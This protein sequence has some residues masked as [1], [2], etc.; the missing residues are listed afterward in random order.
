[1]SL[2]DVMINELRDL[3][4]AELQLT[5]ALPKMAKAASNPEL[6]T[7]FTEHLE[8]TK[9]QVERLKQ[10]FEQIGKKPT[11][12]TCHGMQGLVEEAQQH[13]DEDLLPELKDIALSGAALRVEHY[14]VAGYT[15]SILIAK[16]LG[17][18]QIADLLK[19][20]LEEEKATAKRLLTGAK[21]MLKT[22]ASLA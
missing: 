14:E 19:Q 18:T 5:K 21:P 11:G 1:M 17:E 4:S 15:A 16:Q 12:E 10:I 8:Q 22:A 20:T 3:Y 6:K 13:I 9:L 7:G 2:N